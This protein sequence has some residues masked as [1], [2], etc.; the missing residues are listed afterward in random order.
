VMMMMMMMIVMRTSKLA[1]ETAAEGAQT[2]ACVLI[3]PYSLLRF[4]LCL[5]SSSEFLE[6]RSSRCSSVLIPL[7]R[8]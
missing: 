2:V 7:D 1:G 6:N 8:V 4:F 5:S 3:S